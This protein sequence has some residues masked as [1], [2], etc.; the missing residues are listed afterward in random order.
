[1]GE[2]A[3]N[4]DL[5]RPAVDRDAVAGLIDAGGMLAARGW[6]MGTSGNLSVVVAHGPTRVAITRSGA[7]K[8][9]LAHEHFVEVDDSGAVVAGNGAPSA[10][11]LLHLAVIRCRSVGAVLHTHSPAATILSRR[12]EQNGAVHLDG[13]EM[14]KG[15]EGVESCT[16]SE[17]VPILANRDD[18]DELA[19]E[20]EELLRGLPRC[21]AFLLSGHGM[22]TWGRTLEDARRHAEILE[23]LLDVVERGAAV[24][25]AE[26]GSRGN[27]RP[28]HSR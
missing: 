28:A 2:I 9:R 23:F 4:A 7:D 12:F 16:H 3:D 15:L 17:A 27:G 24:R 5:A 19:V 13:W 22:Y 20:V 21:H 6:L 18:M 14:L 10:E 25:V 8:G 11:T 26:G 1:V